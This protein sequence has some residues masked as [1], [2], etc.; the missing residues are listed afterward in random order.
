MEFRI[1]HREGVAEPSLSGEVSAHVSSAAGDVVDRGATGAFS[2]LQRCF[3][4]P[5]MADIFSEAAMVRSWLDVEAALALTQGEL[6]LIPAD[7]AAAIAAACAGADI[8]HSQVWAGTGNV[9]Y[10][11]L[12]LVRALS[13]LLPDGPDGSVHLGATTQDI[14]DSGLA[15][16]L[17]RAV[18][19]AADVAIQL[20]DQVAELVTEHA[21]T[22]MVGRTHA[23]QALPITLG[24]KLAV[25]LTQVGEGLTDLVRVRERV[26]IVSLHGAVGTSAGF[27]GHGEA[28]RTGVGQRLGLTVPVG[29]WH[30]ARDGLVAYG[31]AMASLSTVCL[32]LAREVIDL[33][34][35]EVGEVRERGGHLRG[36]SSTMPQ[37]ANPIDAEVTVGFATAASSCMPALYRAMEAGHER[38]AGEWQIEWH[39]LPQLSTLTAGALTS[40]TRM[41]S[42]V[43]VD[44]NRMAVNLELE[45]GRLLAEAYMLRLAERLGRERAHDVVY[46]AAMR[47]RTEDVSLELA[48]SEELGGDPV[49]RIDPDGYLGEASQFAALAVES[50]RRDRRDHLAAL[51][52]T[53]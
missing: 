19:R 39:V 17:R 43:A 37:K 42:G 52:R 9:G 16:Q 33:S 23:Q 6:G 29:P 47:S 32:R 21:A 34:R 2:L 20:G 7:H 1:V 38:S 5:V 14:M 12:P 50:W 35:T 26:A 28:I 48:L 4:D 25:F 41:L 18:D 31:A 53:P 49:E 13:E 15:L 30:V 24:G 51:R 11:I 40:A 22:V 45:R 36:A 46:A 10:P 27:R 8:D 3:G 44:R